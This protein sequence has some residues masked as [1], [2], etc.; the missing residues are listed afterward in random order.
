MVFTS[1]GTRAYES[2]DG[3]VWTATEF[4]ATP[5]DWA[6]LNSGFG[7]AE[8]YNVSTDPTNTNRAF[9][10]TQDNSTLQ[11][12]GSLGWTQAGVCGDGLFTAINPISPNIVYAAC[13]GGI[14][15]STTGGASGSWVQLTNGL[16]ALNFIGVAM[17]FATPSTLYI[18]PSL[19]GLPNAFQT[20][21]GGNSW[22]TVG[23]ACPCGYLTVAPSD[24]NT[25]IAFDGSGNLWA[26]TNALSGA[27]STWVDRGPLPVQ[28]EYPFTLTIDP[29]NAKTIYTVGFT[30]TFSLCLFESTDGGATWDAGKDLA[31]TKTLCINKC[32]V[33]D[34]V[35]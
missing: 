31:A 12:S 26:T 17:D 1:D 11:F 4:S 35:D 10:G 8:F 7:T 32:S 14:F 13:N 24:S 6:N 27:S 29:H 15:R 20:L 30:P 25:V 33:C 2:N 22:H 34:I 21:D 28:I 16:P 9:G 18:N 19:S 3:G 23:L 5:M